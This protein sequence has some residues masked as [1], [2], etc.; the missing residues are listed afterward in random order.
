M[1]NRAYAEGAAGPFGYAGLVP[2]AH[3]GSA[4]S[5]REPEFAPASGGFDAS[6]SLLAM[7]SPGLA[8]VSWKPAVPP[9]PTNSQRA[10][11]EWSQ[12]LVRVVAAALATRSRVAIPAATMRA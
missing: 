8:V 6:P 4:V 11:R 1:R 2:R 12:L 5:K 3:L 10:S 9:S 7:R